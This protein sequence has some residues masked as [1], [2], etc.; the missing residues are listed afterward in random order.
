MSLSGVERAVDACG[1][2]WWAHFLW[3]TSWEVGD[4]SGRKAGPQA[5]EEDSGCNVGHWEA[6]DSSSQ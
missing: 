3:A 1:A 4:D 2:L 6:I 5:C